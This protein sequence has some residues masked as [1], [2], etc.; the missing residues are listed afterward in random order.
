M[1]NDVAGAK[2]VGAKNFCRL[3][4]LEVCE[5]NVDK[6]STVDLD[7]NPDI[8]KEIYI[9]EAYIC[10]Y[11]C[12]NCTESWSYIDYKTPE[13]AWKKAKEHLNGSVQS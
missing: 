13:E 11:Y 10:Y 2:L 3:Y 8:E 9:D 5:R 4:D 7:G 6:I 1:T 12:N